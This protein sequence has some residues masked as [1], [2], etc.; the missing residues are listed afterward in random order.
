MLKNPAFTQV[1]LVTGSVRTIY[2]GTQTGVDGSGN[3]VGPGDVAAQTVRAFENLRL[4]LEA[5]GAGPEHLVQWTISQTQ[6]QPRQAPFDAAMRWWVD[7]T[8]PPINTVVFVSSSLA[9]CQARL[10]M[11][12]QHRGRRQRRRRGSA[13]ESPSPRAGY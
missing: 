6:G 3:V 4:C 1:V 10:R 7:R 2:I 5:A 12:L 13:A 8:N 11:Q 9:P